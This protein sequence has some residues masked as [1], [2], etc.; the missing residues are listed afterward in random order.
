MVSFR[1]FRAMYVAEKYICGKWK[2]IG[3]E[4]IQ[5]EQLKQC[6]MLISSNEKQGK[7]ETISETS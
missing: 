1:H 5:D 7:F 4:P 2:R 6:L 3:N